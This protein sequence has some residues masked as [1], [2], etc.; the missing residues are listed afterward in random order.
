MGPDPKTIVTETL[1]TKNDDPNIAE[2]KTR[3]MSRQQKAW[4]AAQDKMILAWDWDF[5]K[6]E[7]IQDERLMMAYQGRRSDD[8]VE[9]AKSADNNKLLTR[10]IQSMRDAY[11]TSGGSE[12]K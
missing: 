9:V 8:L 4:D 5:L 3:L 2:I 7:K 10:G 11:G 1:A 6:R 12:G